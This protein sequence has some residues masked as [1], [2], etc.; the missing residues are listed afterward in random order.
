M[1]GEAVFQQQQSS[2]HQQQFILHKGQHSEAVIHFM[3]MCGHKGLTAELSGW[4]R[5]E[6][7]AIINLNVQ[8][9]CA[10]SPSGQVKS[11]NIIVHSLLAHT[12]KGP[13]ECV[14]LM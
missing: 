3:C 14:L 6:L 8:V 9:L 11:K 4:I 7:Q 10:R 13:C 12:L 5:F 1:L 2:T